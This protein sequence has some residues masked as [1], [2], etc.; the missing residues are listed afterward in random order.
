VHESS[1]ECATRNREDMVRSGAFIILANFISFAPF[2]SEH[3]HKNTHS[4]SYAHIEAACLHTQQ[5]HTD[6]IAGV[7]TQKVS[8]FATVAANILAQLVKVGDSILF[9][10]TAGVPRACVRYL[11]SLIRAEINAR[12]E[13]MR[14]KKTLT[15]QQTHIQDIHNEQKRI[16]KEHLLQLAAG[17]IH[18]HRSTPSGT[19]NNTSR[20]I[21]PSTAREALYRAEEGMSTSSQLLEDVK[22][23][24]CVC[25]NI[26]KGLATHAA[27]ILCAR[28]HGF[29][30]KKM[31]KDDR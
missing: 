24:L 29:A 16:H 30:H 22:T 6:R 17:Q 1:G 4:N 9:A 14:T 20:P 26:V 23:Q 15:Q 12:N 10:N 31:E 25:A 11:K 18:T 27:G 5:T 8:V 3:L 7:S 13:F 28:Q 21:T 2:I 19:N